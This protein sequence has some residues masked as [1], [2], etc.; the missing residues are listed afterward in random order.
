VIEKKIERELV[1]QL[2]REERETR[3]TMLCETG[4][5]IRRVETEKR[6]VYNAGLETPATAPEVIEQPSPA[7]LE[8]FHTSGTDAIAAPADDAEAGQENAE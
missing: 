4:R 7:E 3:S 2:T 5:E 6:N 8:E 1:C